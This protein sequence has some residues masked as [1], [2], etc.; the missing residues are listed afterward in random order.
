M[1]QGVFEISD[2]LMRWAF[3]NVHAVQQA[4][5]ANNAESGGRAELDLI[6]ICYFFLQ[7]LISTCCQSML[8]TLC[9]GQP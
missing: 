9:H 7:C 4:R 2:Y 1:A 5:A 3:L 8:I 6:Q